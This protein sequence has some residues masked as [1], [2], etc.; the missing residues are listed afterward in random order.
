MNIELANDV[1]VSHFIAEQMFSVIE[2]LF[3]IFDINHSDLPN[4][5]CSF[6]FYIPSPVTT[7]VLPYEWLQ[8]VVILQDPFLPFGGTC[9]PTPTFYVTGVLWRKLAS[10]LLMSS[11]VNK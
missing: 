11:P 8:E 6:M 7:F 4:I 1:Y 10:F 5:I 3:Y 9:L 2:I